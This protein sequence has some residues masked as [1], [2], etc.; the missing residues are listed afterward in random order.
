VVNDVF[1]WIY[2]LEDEFEPIRGLDDDNEHGSLNAVPFLPP[3][4]RSWVS[5][6]AQESDAPDGNGLLIQ[7]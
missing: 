1:D 5:P 7:V 4:L 2:A 3:D 6:K